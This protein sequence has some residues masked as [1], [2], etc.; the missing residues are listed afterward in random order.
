MTSYA[1]FNNAVSFGYTERMRRLCHEFDMNFGQGGMHHPEITEGN[2][3]QY[4][5]S[6]LM[7]EAIYS[8]IMKG[9][10]I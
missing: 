2:R 9:A 8:S 1:W 7:D 6:S 3:K 5:N 10:A 4:L